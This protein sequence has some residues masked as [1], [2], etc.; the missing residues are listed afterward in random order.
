MKQKT[1]VNR[2]D[3]QSK[4]LVHWK[5]IN[6]TDKALANWWRK[7]ESRYNFRKEKE[8]INT[9]AITQVKFYEQFIN[10]F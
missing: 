8:I 7:K 10:K 3:Q 1:T 4:M 5:K 9:T 2:K 6:K